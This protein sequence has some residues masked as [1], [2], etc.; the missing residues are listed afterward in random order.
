MDPVLGMAAVAASQTATVGTFHAS[1]P[2]ALLWKVLYRVLRPFSGPIFRRLHARIAVSEEARRSIAQFF[3]GDYQIIPNGIDTD[4]F[5]P[6]V[7][8]FPALGE[9]R[10]TILFVGRADPRKG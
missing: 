10:P 2:P 7:A 4:R 5:H 3:P 6:D 9:H 8:P 1:F